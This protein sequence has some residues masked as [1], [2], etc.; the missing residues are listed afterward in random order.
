MDVP[1]SS[2]QPGGSRFWIGFGICGEP[3]AA[4]DEDFFRTIGREPFVVV[5]WG[6]EYGRRRPNDHASS[7]PAGLK[8]M[9]IRPALLVTKPVREFAGD[10]GRRAEEIKTWAREQVGVLTR[11]MKG[12]A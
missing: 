3:G 6:D 8:E 12:Y 11:V 1:D 2:L 4:F 10:P 7:Y 9:K 5:Y